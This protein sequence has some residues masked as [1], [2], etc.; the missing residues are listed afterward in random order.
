MPLRPRALALLL[1]LAATALPAFSAARPHSRQGRPVPE[2]EALPGVIVVKFLPGVA[3]A[4][5]AAITS[6]VPLNEI[7]ERE[8]V[9]ALRRAFPGLEPPVRA[10]AGE[11][12]VDLS[13]VYYADVPASL[14]PRATAA[15][16]A[17]APG[18]EYAEPKFMHRVADTP[19]DPL[20]TTQTPAF[21]RLN[22]FNGWTLGK[23][24]TSVVI[25]IVDGGTYW[26]HEDLTGSL[27]INT[28]EDINGNRRFDPS[29]APG[30]DLDGIDQD[31]NGF[32]DDVIGWNF[33]NNT[34]N[35]RG[36]TGTPSSATHG[37]N[38]ASMAAAT[39]NNGVG[40]AGSSWGCRLMPVN[41]ASPTQDNGIAYGYEGIVYAYRKGAKIINCSWGRVGGYSNFEQDVMNAATQSGSL[42][43]AAAGN[44]GPDNIGDNNDLLPNY[45]PNYKNVLSVGATS[46]SSDAKAGFSNYG[47]TVPVFAPGVSIVGANDG[48]GYSSFGSGTSFSSPLVAGIAGILKSRNPA[49]TPQQI[50]AQIR[51]TADSID[52]VNPSYAGSMGRGRANLARAL[53]ESHPGIDIVSA[54]IRTTRGS[55]IFLPG[56]T[57]LMTLTVRNVLPPTANNLTF[58]VI[59]TDALLAV[60]QGTAAAGNL[61][62][63]QQVTLPDFRFRVGALTAARNV[64]IKVRWRS[65]TN[66]DDQWAFRATLFPATPQ[67]VSQVS[68]TGTGLFSVKAVSRTV[69][70]ASG[71]NSSA[72]AP[73]VI[74]TTD[75]G[76]TWLQATGNLTGVDAYAI[77]AVDGNRAWVGTGNGRIYATSDGG[78]TWT[79]QVYPGTQSPFING[80]WMFPNGTGYAQGDP[81]SGGRFV[82]LK[83]TNFG[84][85]WAH[86]NEPVGGAT[87]AGWNN[88][89]WLTDQ[90]SLWFGTNASRVWR[91]TDGGAT[92]SSA[93]SG[94]TNSF[95]VAF[96]DNSNGIVVHTAGVLR[97]TTNG[98]ATWN[99]ASSPTSSDLNGVAFL[100][101]T[102]SA[103]ISNGTNPFRST[104]N[105]SS[106][107]AQ[108]LFPF[109][110]SITHLSFTD[111]TAGWVVTTN[112]EVLKYQLSGSTGVEAEGADVPGAFALEQNYPNPF[113]PVTAI[114]FTV[115]SATQVRLA[116]YDLLGRE[117]AVLVDGVVGA[118]GHAV[119]FDAS[120]L[121]SGIYLYRL[122]AGGDVL[123]RKMVLL[124]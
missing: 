8:G 4:E 70:W 15:A 74:R 61:A 77:T 65:N 45:P 24:D 111:T 78:A 97:T 56:D 94:S 106:W 90:N 96:K 30:G 64:L 7:L 19:N 10:A 32:V 116:V 121:A 63:G 79:Q 120:G 118:G 104:N 100:A 92:W 98:G 110:G 20:V 109:S 58:N 119:S 28:P 25:A 53:T 105:G 2:G 51:V 87:E 124:R 11:E 39:T 81:A 33:A 27:W 112:G 14:D 16:L 36:L 86:T 69:A 55:S 123:T 52:G 71:G 67:W 31:A 115:Q 80:V 91:S 38:T 46:A 57:V 12:T 66:D 49:L 22:L 113:N 114:R 84:A 21:T 85:A 62:S 29:P 5:G 102:T 59:T 108:S 47:S 99:A 6:S 9:A 40:M 18:V 37:T 101:G 26:Q 93:S 73:V 43:V 13:R 17:A 88:S 23:G 42:V 68:P 48:G 76:T 122:T 3:V 107:T 72:T 82:V 1:L 54:N 83:T 89:F 117:V 95:G 41:A 60:L 75:G 35:P 50:A 34:N 103:W 44:G